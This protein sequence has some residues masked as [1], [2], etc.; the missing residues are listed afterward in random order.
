MKGIKMPLSETLR[1]AA[2]R[3]A[4]TSLYARTFTAIILVSI[5]TAINFLK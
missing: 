1:L 2:G 4:T 5:L 3:K